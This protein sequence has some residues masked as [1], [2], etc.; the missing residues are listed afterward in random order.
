[1]STDEEVDIKTRNDFPPELP[2][3]SLPPTQKL[4]KDVWGDLFLLAIVGLSLV[5][6]KWGVMKAESFE[7][8]VFGVLFIKATM[9]TGKGISLDALPFVRK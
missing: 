7:K 8:V 5:S 3:A 1:M 9:L 6:A 4:A 2:K